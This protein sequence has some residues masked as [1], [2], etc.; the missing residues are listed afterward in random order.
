MTRSDTE[1]PDFVKTWRGKRYVT[2]RC[3]N[4]GQDFYVDEPEAGIPEK[5]LTGNELINDEE[6]LHAAEEE[7]RREIED[8]DDRRFG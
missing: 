4:C 1:Q 2:C 6:A 7:L 3:L 5:I 8:N